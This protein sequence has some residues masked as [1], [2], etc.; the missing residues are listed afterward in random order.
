MENAGYGSFITCKKQI[1]EMN[2]CLR[3]WYTDKDFRKECEQ[4][5]LEKRKKFRETGIIEKEE[6]PAYYTSSKKQKAPEMYKNE[7]NSN[8]SSSKK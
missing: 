8:E 2:T 7:S 4:M 6:K 5:Y 3:H 1:D